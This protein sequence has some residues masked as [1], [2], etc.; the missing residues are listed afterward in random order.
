MTTRRGRVCDNTSNSYPPSLCIINAS[1]AIWQKTTSTA[2]QTSVPDPTTTTAKEEK[3]TKKEQSHALFSSEKSHTHAQLI[4]FVEGAFSYIHAVVMAEISPVFQIENLLREFPKFMTAN[5]ARKLAKP[6]YFQLVRPS[7]MFLRT[8][9]VVVAFFLLLLRSYSSLLRLTRFYNIRPQPNPIC[10]P[11]TWHTMGI[12]I[13]PQPKKEKRKKKKRK[14]VPGTSVSASTLPFIRLEKLVDDGFCSAF[15]FVHM[16]INF[17]IRIHLYQFFWFFLRVFEVAVLF[18]WCGIFCI[19]CKS[20]MP[21]EFRSFFF[22]LS[23]SQQK[24]KRK[25]KMTLFFVL[26]LLFMFVC[27]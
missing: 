27:V 18:R 17:Y 20:N 25:L 1:A 21:G 26:L 14:S 2:C 24:V 5:M 22:S 10:S 3:K 12:W 23:S 4:Q 8:V 11:I 13:H 19:V 16:N 15:N 6:F 7:C 9:A